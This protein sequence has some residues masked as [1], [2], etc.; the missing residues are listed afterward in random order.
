M[1]PDR[2]VLRMRTQPKKPTTISQTLRKKQVF[3]YVLLVLV[4]A[5]MVTPLVVLVSTSLK[6]FTQIVADPMTLVPRP[7]SLE[8]YA[9]VF[10][11]MPFLRYLFNTVFIT[12]LQIT[13][14]VFTSLLVAYGFSRFPFKHKEIIFIAFLLGMMVPTQ[15]LTIPIFELYSNFGWINTFLPFIVP[16]FFGGGIFNI[17][18]ARQFFRG[19]PKS[20]Y[21]SAELDGASEFKIFM[22][23]AIPLSKPVLLTI[24]I[25][26][27]INS[28][29]DLFGP[30]LYLQDDR[31]W[32]IAKGTYELYTQTMAGGGQPNWA[33]LS[34][35]N[36]VVIIPV[37]FIYF[38]AQR[39]FIE[40]ISFTGLKG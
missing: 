33:L 1:N 4:G 34:A 39:Y 2:D 32:T 29:N 10:T 27:F 13:G 3:T 25:F 23:I 30:L 14:T 20:L 8:A 12:V 24:A 28:W 38:F 9:R 11:E 40:G 16:P 18:L 15:V 35:A 17:F 26:T 19:I 36:V 21:E 7:F 6:T 31:L 22:K 5:L 37:V